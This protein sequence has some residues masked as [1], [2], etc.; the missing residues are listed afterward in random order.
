MS[1]C[2]VCGRQVHPLHRLP[3]T[4]SCYGRRYVARTYAELNEL[5]DYLVDRRLALANRFR[6]GTSWPRG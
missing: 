2:D 5:L 6:T 3:V 1:L 4:V